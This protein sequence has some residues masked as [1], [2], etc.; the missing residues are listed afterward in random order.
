ME[1]H[2]GSAATPF[3]TSWW[4]PGYSNYNQRTTPSTWTGP[5]VVSPYSRYVYNN[6]NNTNNGNPYA[7]DH[8]V[9]QNVPTEQGLVETDIVSATAQTQNQK[10]PEAFSSP[11][12]HDIAERSSVKTSGDI[13]S[14]LEPAAQH[15]ASSSRQLSNMASVKKEEKKENQ[16]G[17][18]ASTIE[19]NGEKKVDDGDGDGDNTKPDPCTPPEPKKETFDDFVLRDWY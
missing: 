11:T 1:N 7:H 13:H 19:K 15:E 5:V 10:E 6:G 14:E 2:S 18:C 17:A 8:P 9:S 4:W 16:D 12:A 3:A